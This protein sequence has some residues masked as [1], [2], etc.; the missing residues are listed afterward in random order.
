MHSDWLLLRCR[1]GPRS[2]VFSEPVSGNATR[3]RRSALMNHKTHPYRAAP[4]RRQPRRDASPCTRRSRS[5][6]RARGGSYLRRTASSLTTTREDVRLG[7]ASTR[8]PARSGTRSILAGALCYT[9]IYIHQESP[10]RMPRSVRWILPG[11]LGIS[12]STLGPGRSSSRLIRDR[13]LVPTRR[14][15]MT[16]RGTSSSECVGTRA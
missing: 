2:N 13:R 14:G 16:V 4:R 7:D 6:R 15:A 5:T 8:S 1:G 11:V 10:L 3:G 9:C 12:E